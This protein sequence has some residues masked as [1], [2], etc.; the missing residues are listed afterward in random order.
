MSPVRVRIDGSWRSGITVDLRD[1]P[2]SC[3]ITREGLT[4]AVTAAMRPESGCRASDGI[5]GRNR[6]EGRI[7]VEVEVEVECIEPSTP[8]ALDRVPS[9]GSLRTTLAAA[10]RSRGWTASVAGELAERRRDLSTLDVPDV[11]VETARRRVAETGTDVDRLKEEIAAIR[12]ELSARR[13]L[14]SDPDPV[15]ERLAAATTRLAETETTHIAARQD[16]DRARRRGRA[17]RDV[18]ERRLRLEDEIGNLER[19]A[20]RELARR[21]YPVVRGR[22]AELPIDPGPIGGTVDEFRGDPALAGLAAGAVAGRRAPVVCVSAA[23]SDREQDPLGA[24]ASSI[25]RR[26]GYPIVRV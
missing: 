3:G 1:V 20:R 7:D 2:E 5:R 19:A 23:R 26:L 24:C 18:R 11:E 14:D 16:L 12:G 17:A 6:A 10:A 13:E 22:L 8:M 4:R 15:R 9:V 21:L 25:A